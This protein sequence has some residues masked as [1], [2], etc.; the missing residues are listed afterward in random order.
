[1][2]PRGVLAI[3]GLVAAGLGVLPP[4]A[5]A[6]TG[7]APDGIGER[8]GYKFEG[9]KLNDRL[10]LKVNVATGNLLVKATDLTIAGTGLSAEVDRFYNSLSTWNEAM[11]PGW[12]LG[13][14]HDV[15]LVVTSTD[16]TFHAPSGYQARFNVNADGTYTA[17]AD[18]GIDATLTKKADG[19]YELKWH[20]KEKYLFDSTGLW[21]KHVDKNDNALT[22]SYNAS[23]QVSQ[24]TD[25]RGR[26][27]TFTYAN[28]RLTAVSDN[29]GGRTYS[30]SY[31]T[32]GR[33]ATSAITTYSLA[34]DNVNLG[35]QT[36]YAYDTSNRLTRITDP[37][38]NATTFTYDGTT[39]K[40]RTITRVLDPTTGTG[41][42]TTFT[43]LTTRDKCANETNAVKETKVDG[44][45]TDVVD[46]TSHCLDSH[47]RSVSV[48]DAKGNKRSTKYASNSNVAQLN[49]SGVESGPA[50]GYEWTSGN[51]LA[52]VSLPTGGQSYY[53]YGDA[54]N[55]HLPTSVRDFSAGSRTA[56]STWDYD[57]DDDGNMIEAKNATTGITYRYCYNGNGTVDR[58]APPSLDGLPLDD[59]TTASAC[60]GFAQGN[61]TLFTYNTKGE[62]V[63][64]NPPG[65]R[66]G[67]SLS[68][69]PLSRL[70]SRR[71]A[72]GVTASYS[73]DAL[74]RITRIAY[75]A[76][77]GTSIPMTALVPPDDDDAR[78]VWIT[79]SYDE[80]GNMTARL[81]S[82]GNSTFQYDALNR[83]TKESPEAPSAVTTYTYDLAGNPL[84][85]SS[86]DEPAAV[87]YAYDSTNLVT[88]IVDQENRT[89]T[90]SYNKKGARRKTAYPNGVAMEWRYDDAGRVTCA[91]SYK[92]TAPA[93]DPNAEESCPAASTSLL[94]FYKYEYGALLGGVMTDT[95]RR[96]KTTERDSS[97]TTYGYDAIG[98]LIRVTKKST[99]GTVL[100]EH[101]YTYDAESNLTREQVT[102]SAATAETRTQA[103]DVDGALC[104]T[105]SGSPT[106]ACTSVPAGATTYTYSPDGSLTTSSAGFGATYSLRGHTVEVTP[107]GGAAIPMK[108]T[109]ATQDRRILVGTIA[110]AY[111]QLGLSSQ[112]STSGASNATWFPRDPNGT[113]VGMLAANSTT[114]DLYYL[115]DGLGSVVGTTD[116]AGTLVKRYEYE[117]FGEEIGA[118][119]TD[120]NPW[121]YAGGY[122]DNATKMLKFGTRYYMPNLGRWTQRDPVTGPLTNPIALNPYAYS[123][124]DPVNSIDSSGR[125]PCGIAPAFNIAFGAYKVAKGIGALV[126]GAAQLPFGIT[127][128]TG[129]MAI[130]Y[131]VYQLGTGAA[132]LY[133]GAWK[134]RDMWTR[135]DCSARD[136]IA[137]V[138][139]GG[140]STMDFLGGLL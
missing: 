1:L 48:F 135:T 115:F 123:G 122:Y 49:E 13:V 116:G 73:Y 81:D 14:G 98:R 32:V 19:T 10:E 139:P 7:T 63:F 134:Q 112:S 35:K 91:Y 53:D 101:T 78:T 17:P 114:A 40:V 113:L 23:R 16:V 6:G 102:G 82:N 121:R 108:Y 15:R 30:Y 20:S 132:R 59:N 126:T 37:R 131:G 51:Q 47:D 120:T 118:S 76:P 86:S 138:I 75:D 109:D 28:G 44:P 119:S 26:T 103:Y 2:R 64:V 127:T 38:G 21:T 70:A 50:T 88:S 89:T 9:Q 18:P 95:N 11:G 105:A 133:R 93:T 140:D 90:F 117:P 54:A 128:L 56:P 43:Y 96:E 66:A 33:L 27:I 3:A 62:L 125:L 45:R 25:T 24:L 137:G 106:S 58:V 124:C 4:I 94:T 36:L 71:D 100:R 31:D 67:V 97:V 136:L 74:D 130:A 72:R 34:T 107:P 104:W 129:G 110:M 41:A 92:G 8:K 80:N 5:H 79:Y 60:A 52:S 39:R 22:L 111:N 84:T 55:T 69:D 85:V 99:A 46:V 57:Y 87:R 77:V 29:S 65:P 42:T 61:D 12:I 68:Y 83:M